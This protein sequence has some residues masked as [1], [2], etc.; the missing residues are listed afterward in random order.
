MTLAPA[1]TLRGAV[2]RLLRLL[3]GPEARK[4]LRQVLLLARQLLLPLVEER[5][6]RIEVAELLLDADLQLERPPR[7]ILAPC[8]ERL[9]RLALQLD[10]LLLEAPRLKL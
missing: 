8:G 7:E 10:E 4:R 9:A 3:L 2:A 1:I 6:L 5:Q